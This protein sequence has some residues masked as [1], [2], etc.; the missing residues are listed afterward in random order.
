RVIF[1]DVVFRFRS[2]IKLT[3]LKDVV[4]FSDIECD[5]LLRLY[6]RSWDVTG[7]HDPASGL[8]R[9]V[10]ETG[11]LANDIAATKSL[12]AAIKQRRKTRNA[13]TTPTVT[14]KGPSIWHW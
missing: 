5:E 9:P 4:G 14:P 13:T 1:S 10:T 11:D 8:H 7:A 3:Y 2:H 6:Q 12:L